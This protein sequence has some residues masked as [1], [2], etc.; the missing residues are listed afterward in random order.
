MF[1]VTCRETFLHQNNCCKQ[2]VKTALIRI[3][4]FSPHTSFS[5]Q[6]PATHKLLGAE[7]ETPKGSLSLPQRQDN[8]TLKARVLCWRS[9]SMHHMR[10]NSLCM[11]LLFLFIA[12]LYI[13]SFLVAIMHL[14]SVLWGYIFL[15]CFIT[16]IL[17]S[18]HLFRL[19]LSCTLKSLNDL[20][21]YGTCCSVFIFFLKAP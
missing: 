5:Y 7:G 12:K 13:L 1:K 15:I 20:T 14:H 2:L 3:S 8:L 11:T 4:A 19:L 18:R 10:F 17:F 6:T 21:L 9:V 16:L